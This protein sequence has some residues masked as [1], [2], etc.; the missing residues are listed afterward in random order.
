MAGS[1]NIGFI[2]TRL[3][4]TDGVS[5]EAKKWV[6]VFNQMGFECFCFA[7]ESDWPKDRAYVVPE[8]HFEHPAV[9]ELSIDLFDDNIRSPLTSEKIENIKNRLKKHLHAFLKDFEI[10]VIIVENALSIPMNVPL[11]LAI[12][13]LIAETEIRTIAHHHDFAWERRRFSVSAAQDYLR[14]AFP[15]TLNSVIHVVINSFGQSQLAYRAG[16]SSMIIPNVMDFDSSPPPNDGYSEDLKQVLDIPEE[17]FLFLQP[18]RIVPRK[19]IERAIELVKRLDSPAT[20]IISHASGDEGNT[21][22]N[23]LMDYI[24]LLQVDVRFAA[25]F[26]AD[27]RGFTSDS[28]KTYSLEDAYQAAQLVTYPSTIEGF[29]NAFLEAVYY[30]K[31]VVMSAYSIYRTDIKPKGFQVIEFDNY[32][33]DDTVKQTTKILNN[34]ELIHQM[35]SHNYEIAKQHFSYTTLKRCLSA[36]VHVSFGSSL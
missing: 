9:Q 1:N 19:R 6:H 13:E 7:G 28:R 32:I 31:P 20:L 15:P 25:E 21:Y 33:T 18:T 36:L 5:L 2:S 22:V 30:K 17:N 34:R 27:E 24:R 8:A 16:V 11:G 10:D 12:T 23:Y 29:G 4:G 26:F 3:A 35:V 14:A